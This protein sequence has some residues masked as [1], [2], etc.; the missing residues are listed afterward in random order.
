MRALAAAFGLI[1]LASTPALADAHGET[2]AGRVGGSPA[3]RL[4][5]VHKLAKRGPDG[6]DAL[7]LALADGDAAVRAEA[8]RALGRLR[9]NGAIFALGRALFDAEGRV[10][11]AAFEALASYCN[12]E[13]LEPLVDLTLKGEA[14]GDVQRAAIDFLR[15][16]GHAQFVRHFWQARWTSTE[17]EERTRAVKLMELSANPQALP[18]LIAGL[19]DREPIVRMLALQGLERL[20]EPQVLAA[21]DA[22]LGRETNERVVRIAS[23]AGQRLRQIR[24]L[25]RRPGIQVVQLTGGTNARP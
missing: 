10:R 9:L 7:V 22:L 21:I 1:L 3:A 16:N 5:A 20:A 15:R 24:G 25:P 19:N 8:A 6:A 14:P 4:A 13:S 11:M 12:D 17:K 2:G 23:A 18:L